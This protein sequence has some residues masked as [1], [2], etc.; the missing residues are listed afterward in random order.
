MTTRNPM[1]RRTHPART[2][3]R[4]NGQHGI[5]LLEA[6]IAMLIFMLGVL[7]LIGL[8]TSMTSAQT[9]AKFR[10]DAAYLASE[11]VGRMWADLGH[12]NDYNG[13]DSCSATACSEW[14]A[15]VGQ[16]LPG[17][18][19]SITVDSTNSD[20]TVVVRWTSPTGETHQYTTRSAVLGKAS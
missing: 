19:A 1:P 2:I 20:V 9:D 8:Q 10:A 15:K 14:R 6:L 7:G 13:E 11:V 16:L 12:L 17:G 3:R 4:A 5:V 18:G